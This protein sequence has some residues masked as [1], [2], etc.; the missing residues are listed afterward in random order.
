MPS[1]SRK[2]RMR[3]AP[4][5]FEPSVP[6]PPDERFFDLDD[7]TDPQEVLTRSTDLAE[8]FRAAA[9]RAVDYQAMAAARMADPN[10]FDHLTTA[11]VAARA[12]WGEEYTAKMIEHGRKLLLERGE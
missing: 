10:R 9:D 11:Q 3:P 7:L 6:E 4:L 8:A 5:L 2:P 12:G 1:E